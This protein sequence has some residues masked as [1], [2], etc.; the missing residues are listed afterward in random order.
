MP[1][2]LPKT[3]VIPISDFYT[4][5][6]L[7][8]ISYKCRALIYHRPFDKKKFMEICDKK[9]EKILQISLKN[10]LP[11]IFNNKEQQKKYTLRF[12]GQTGIPAFCYRDDYQIAIKG[13]WDLYYYFTV[14]ASVRCCINGEVEIGN[15]LSNDIKAGTLVA[16]L[17]SG[18]IE[19]TFHNCSRIFPSNF[20][21]DLFT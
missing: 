6:Q 1:S 14:G 13:Y 15:I 7:E 20:Y 17:D 19:I 18:H 12:F 2:Q 21:E 8:W 11:S 5:L 16:K 9:K 4:R 10:C 3:R